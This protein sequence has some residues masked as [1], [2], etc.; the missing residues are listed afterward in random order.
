MTQVINFNRNDVSGKLTSGFVS[1][2]CVFSLTFEFLLKFANSLGF[3]CKM[4]FPS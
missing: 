4:F 1:R 2:D 3:G